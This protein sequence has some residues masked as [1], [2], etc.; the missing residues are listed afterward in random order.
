V[1]FAHRVS[2]EFASFLFAVAFT[3][4]FALVLKIMALRGWRIV[5]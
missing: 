2:P 3:A 1:P 5:I 4:V